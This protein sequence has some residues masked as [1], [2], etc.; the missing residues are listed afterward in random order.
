MA[1]EEEDRSGGIP[2]LMHEFVAQLRGVT[3]RLEGL[4]RVGESL[5]SLPPALSQSL[6]SLRN[7]PTPGVLSAA[8]LNALATNVDAQRRSIQTLKTD[9]EAFDRQ[10]AVLARLLGPLV[11]WSR[12]WAELEERLTGRW[13][14]GEGRADGS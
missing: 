14:A 13:R 1:D 9:L 11:E 5:P 2:G 3:E 12:T 4:T 10:L 6:S 8:Q 7:L